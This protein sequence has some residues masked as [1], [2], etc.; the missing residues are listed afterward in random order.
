MEIRIRSSIFIMKYFIIL[1]QLLSSSIL[2]AQVDSSTSKDAEKRLSI[3]QVF[4][5]KTLSNIITFQTIE[6]TTQLHNG[7]EMFKTTREVEYTIKENE[8]RISIKREVINSST[9]NGCD[10]D[11][12]F[13]D[14]TNKLLSVVLTP[15]NIKK[16][17]EKK[18]L[19]YSINR[20]NETTK[21]CINK[22][23]GIGEKTEAKAMKETL[24][25][26]NISECITYGSMA[27]NLYFDDIESICTT[28]ELNVVS[29][30]GVSK[31][32]K[33][34]ENIIIKANTKI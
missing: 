32:V 6:I 7:Q 15:G 33:V 12:I 22:L 29:K 16:N 24:K 30:S 20:N 21:V 10:A 25:F 13:P 23:I 27:D 26:E 28:I 1:L 14:M 9:T 11:S 2:Y 4:T 18:L 5:N 3:L 17:N 31:N 34:I 8:K 19:P